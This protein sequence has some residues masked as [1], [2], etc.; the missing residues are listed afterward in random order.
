[1]VDTHRSFSGRSSRVQLARPL[2]VFLRGLRGA[3][4]GVVVA[5][6][7]RC[8]STATGLPVAAMPSATFFAQPS[9]MP[10]TTTAA[11]LGFAAGADQRAEVQVEV[12]AELQPAIGCGM[13]ERALDVVARRPRAA[14]FDRSSTGRMMTWLRTPMRPFS[15]L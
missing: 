1:M 12:R 11:T 4:D 8:R 5:V 3:H 13:R 6:A 14:A 10:I 15:R 2:H 9:S 7:A